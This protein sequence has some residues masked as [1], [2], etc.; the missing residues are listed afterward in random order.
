MVL[1]D[2]RHSEDS[3]KRATPHAMDPYSKEIPSPT[4]KTVAKVAAMFEVD[5]ENPH[6]LSS[7]WS[8][9]FAG[10]P[11]TTRLSDILLHVV[12][13]SRCWWIRGG[14]FLP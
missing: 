13:L 9:C 1:D 3:W 8:Q 5:V 6:L 12:L 10:V 7:K 14:W 2:R 11:R 4:R